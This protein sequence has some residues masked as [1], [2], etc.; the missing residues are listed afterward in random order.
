[1]E[2]NKSGP[3]Y[4]PKEMFDITYWNTS[5]EL[6]KKGYKIW[7]D[8]YDKWV[9]GSEQDPSPGYVGHLRCA[10]AFNAAVSE[11]YGDNDKKNLKLLD[12]GCGTGLVGEILKEKYG[13]DN[14]VGLD[15]SEDMLEKAKESTRSSFAH[16]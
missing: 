16:M 1:M 4:Y 2:T 9:N 14:L 10:D 7:A 11:I 12:L 5:E 3:V 15:V 13:F 6:V 8:T